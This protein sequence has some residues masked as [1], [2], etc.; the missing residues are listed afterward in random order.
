V[1]FDQDGRFLG[2]SAEGP[3][4]AWPAS[5]Q[6]RETHADPIELFSLVQG[7]AANRPAALQGVIWYRLPVAPDILNW[8]WPTLAAMLGGRSPR[9]SF[10]AESRRV[11]AGLVEISLVNDGELDIASRLAVPVR[12]PREGG[13]RLI[14]G[15]GLCGFAL[16]DGAPFSIVLQSKK[17]PM[18]LPAGEK[19]VIGWLRLSQD[20][21]VQVEIKKL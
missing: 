2:L 5:V 13:T 18:R 12:W 14:A 21:E 4:Q 20:C 9:E 19:Q 15:D 10:K 17:S 6:I 16:L 3:A 8:R 7:L 11:E 1:A